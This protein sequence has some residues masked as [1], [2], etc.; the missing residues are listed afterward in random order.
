MLNDVKTVVN[1]AAQMSKLLIPL[2]IIPDP[3]FF[4]KLLVIDDIRPKRRMK[5]PQLACEAA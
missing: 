5:P 3:A 1:T 2:R 4:P